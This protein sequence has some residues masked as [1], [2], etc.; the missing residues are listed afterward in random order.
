MAS[1]HLDLVRSILADWERG[2]YSSADWA[3]AEIEFVMA[4][5][6]SSGSWTGTAQM[7]AAWRDFLEAWDSLRTEVEGYRE[8]DDQRV[9]ALTSAGAARGKTSGLEATDMRWKGATLFEVRGGKV[10]RLVLY[11]D[12]DRALADLGLTPEDAAHADD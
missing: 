4:D 9:L 6:P 12:R 8:L 7:A 2:D 3:D 11:M 1:A 5:L 10:T